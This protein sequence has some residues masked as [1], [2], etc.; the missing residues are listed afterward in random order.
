MNDD[1]D[2]QI[3]FPD[4]T[5]DE[6]PEPEPEPESPDVDPVIV[7]LLE[8]RKWTTAKAKANP[9]QWSARKDWHDNAAF[10]KTVL[11]IRAHG[12]HVMFWGRPYICLDVN[13]HTYWTM[14]DPLAT[15]WIINRK[16]KGT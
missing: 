13:D 4:G 11:Y 2:D 10:D 9:H 7:D 15:T 16:V 8:R 14:G 3:P 1:L 5:E 6:N 12:Y